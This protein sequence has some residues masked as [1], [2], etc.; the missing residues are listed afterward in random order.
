M[1]KVRAT[2]A[3]SALLC[4]AP[5]ALPS[6]AAN[7]PARLLVQVT[8]P[9]I[10]VGGSVDAVVQLRDANNDPANARKTYWIYIEVRD[11]DR[12]IEDPQSVAIQAGSNALH[13]SIA[14]S[15]V[16]VFMIKASNGE[17][18]DGAIFVNVRAKPR[19][20]M[21]RGRAIEGVRLLDVAFQ[22]V[23]GRAELAVRSSD[24]GSSL[25][26]NGKDA[27]I[28]QAFLLGDPVAFDIKLLFSCPGYDLSPNPL[29]IKS[30][31]GQGEAR[32]TANA[33]G[34]A[35]IELITVDPQARVL[36]PDFRK[37]I[38]FY[39]PIGGVLVQ[40]A[41]TPI[42]LVDPAEDVSIQLKGLDGQPM[43]PDQQLAV[44]LG[45]VGGGEVNK[46]SVTLAPDRAVETVQFTPK[47]RGTATITAITSGAQGSGSIEVVVPWA[48]LVATVVG[49][50][51]GGLGSLLLGKRFGG[52]RPAL[53]RG[54]LGVL[55]ALVFYWGI[56]TGL[57][58]IPAAVFGTTLFAFLGSLLA[59]YLG[60]KVIDATWSV[61]SSLLPKSTPTAG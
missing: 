37:P 26:A 40:P 11:H 9:T 22:P 25:S 39:R 4:A 47:G 20:A 51:L 8:R 52:W 61:I 24:E 38:Q 27:A 15:H 17:L 45:V 59:G 12:Q 36:K 18:R 50:F 5:A 42:S 23:P 14:M 46:S 41:R 34:T 43:T 19:L 16:G 33:A 7:V 32:L 29:I 21:D 30:G 31:D 6:Q 53:L 58:H 13:V 48:A 55:A 56:E 10:T 35:A 2:M 28:I 1:L 54:L 49:G 3:V 44:T 60:T 57:L